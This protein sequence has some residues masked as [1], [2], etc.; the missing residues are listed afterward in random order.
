MTAIGLPGT[1]VVSNLPPTDNGEV[2]NLWVTTEAGARPIYVGTLPA[3]SASGA[4]SFDFSLGSTMV[5]PSGFVLTVKQVD[6]RSGGRTFEASATVPAV[7]G[8]PVALLE[9]SRRLRLDLGE[10]RQEVDGTTLSPAAVA[11]VPPE[12]VRLR[13]EAADFRAEGRIGQQRAALLKA[14]AVDPGNPGLNLE[15]YAEEGDPRYLAAM[16]GDSDHTI[17][18]FDWRKRVRLAEGKGHNGCVDSLKFNP[19][20]A[21]AFASCGEKHREPPPRTRGPLCSLI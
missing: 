10:G 16:A 14:L 18:V 7:E 6:L 1:L 13:W 2:Y 5:L 21:S 4:D 8:L 20:S 11:P 17:S 9:L 12:I 19:F 3:D 15:R